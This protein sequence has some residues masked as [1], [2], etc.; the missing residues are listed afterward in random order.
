[1][2]TR[3]DFNFPITRIEQGD[4]T[5]DGV[6]VF[7]V[8]AVSGMDDAMAVSIAEGIK[9][10]TCPAGVTI[11]GTLTRTDT[12]TATVTADLNAEPPTWG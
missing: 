9:N 7:S 2:T 5:I 11:T 6:I 12:T 8:D 10:A 4:P 1:M 3:Y